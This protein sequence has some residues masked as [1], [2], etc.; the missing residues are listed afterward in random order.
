MNDD[1]DWFWAERA[2]GHLDFDVPRARVLFLPL[3]GAAAFVGG[4]LVGRVFWG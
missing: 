3:L 1:H 2:P 4:L